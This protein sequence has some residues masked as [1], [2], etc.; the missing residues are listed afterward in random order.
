MGR[1]TDYAFVVLSCFAKRDDRL[2]NA[3]DVAAETGLPQ[4]TVSKLLKI[5]T[6]HGLLSARRGVKG[7]YSLAKPAEDVSAREVIEALEGPIAL[8]DCA[9]AGRKD[10][11][12]AIE[13]GCPTKAHW[14]LISQAICGALS[15]VSLQ[16]LMSAHENNN[17]DRHSAATGCGS[18]CGSP[19]DKPCQCTD[20]KPQYMGAVK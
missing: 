17:F 6:R 18:A 7:G 9:D 20:H 19:P 14:Q 10:H 13:D 8:T 11:D 3:T 15:Q 1:L 16:A 4:P 5:L 2:F 12:C